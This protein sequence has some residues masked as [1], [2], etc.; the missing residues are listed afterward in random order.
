MRRRLVIS[1]IAVGTAALLAGAFF[2]SAYFY[3]RT[4]A[5]RI[6][7]GVVVAGVPVGGLDAAEARTRVQRAVLPSL[8]KP[9]TLVFR[10]R[11]FRISPR[12][13][14]LTVSVDAMVAQA[15][16]ASRSGS[17]LHRFFRDVRGKNVRLAVPLAA[18][19][20][21]DSVTH[22][23]ARLASVIAQRPRP[24]KIV[25]SPTSLLV[26][27]SRAGVRVRRDVLARELA[28]RLVD[29]KA[30]RVVP[31]PVSVVEPRVT[32]AS[33][34]RKFPA[35]ILVSRETYTLRLF[36]GL[37]LYR[38]YHIAVGRQGLETPSGLYRINDKQVDPAWH[39]PNSAWAGSLAGRVIPPGP[40]DPIKARW[41]GF[42]NGAGIHG[43][44]ETWSI[45]HAASHGCIR[46]LI[47]DVEQ[48]YNLVPLG[49]P[50]YVG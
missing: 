10:D 38:M 33:L 44:D 50:I 34:H 27:P 30:S 8:Q 2:A 41:M 28:Q 39:V 37:R 31:I 14:G 21:Q 32:T 6:A 35:Y 4:N 7:A 13:A 42:W 12:G 48:L 15:L 9:L 47:P 43:T 24:A 5:N 16:A 19:F 17:F 45:G 49:T 3:D 40:A 46:M 25:P 23:T 18:V 22:L 29:P 36:R 20:S 26:R 1:G 11:S